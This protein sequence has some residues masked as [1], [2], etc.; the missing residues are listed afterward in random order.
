[1]S[2]RTEMTI[3]L[4]LLNDLEEERACVAG[5]FV[6]PNPREDHE[7]SR[8]EKPGWEWGNE[9]SEL[10]LGPPRVAGFEVQVRGLNRPTDRI[11]RTG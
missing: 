7:R 5:T 8:A 3:A 2:D 4:S 9:V 10:C 11:V 1:M 6:Q